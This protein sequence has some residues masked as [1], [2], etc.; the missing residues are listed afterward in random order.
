MQGLPCLIKR[1]KALDPRDAV[2]TGQ[3]AARSRQLSRILDD[4]T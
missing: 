2:A 4:S 3:H 1:R